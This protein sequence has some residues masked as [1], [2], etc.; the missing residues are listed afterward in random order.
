[1]CSDRLTIKSGG[2]SHKS[3]PAC[4]PAIFGCLP[5]ILGCRLQIRSEEIGDLLQVG[6]WFYQV[7]QSERLF[8]F[9][10]PFAERFKELCWH[11]VEDRPSPL[12]LLS[13]FAHRMSH[14]VDEHIPDL[15]HIPHRSSLFSRVVIHWLLFVVS[16]RPPLSS[17]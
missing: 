16:C 14:R 2:S 10:R 3:R 9:R 6:S 13:A 17:W 1:M 12:V 11:F 8:I 5:L 7:R 15:P 4:L